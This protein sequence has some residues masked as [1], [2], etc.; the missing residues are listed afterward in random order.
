MIFSN[1]LKKVKNIKGKFSGANFPLRFIKTVVAE[2]SK[3]ANNS[4]ETNKNEMI[5]PPQLFEIPK[6]ILFLQ[7][8]FCEL[9]EE[10]SKIFLTKFCNFTNEKFKLIIR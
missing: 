1:F 2:F 4:N 9:N 6:R 8:Q 7:A 10:R 5:I 3:N